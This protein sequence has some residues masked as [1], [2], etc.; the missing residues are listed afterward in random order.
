MSKSSDIIHMDE[1]GAL[2]VGAG[3]V[4]FDAIIASHRAGHPAAAILSRFPK[5]TS[6]ELEAA[7]HYHLHEDDVGHGE[8]HR[9]TN[10][11]RW[12]ATLEDDMGTDTPPNEPV[13]KTD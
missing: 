13:R 8:H 1:S 3:G 7:L 4:P 10:W 12:D 9:D 11:R 5:L 2:C 6:A